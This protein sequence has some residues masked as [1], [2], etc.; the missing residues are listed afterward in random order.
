MLHAAQLPRLTPHGEMVGPDG[1]IRA[2]GRAVT[3]QSRNRSGTGNSGHWNRE[4]G[5]GRL[6]A[7]AISLSDSARSKL[8]GT[9]GVGYGQGKFSDSNNGR[10]LLRNSLRSARVGAIKDYRAFDR[11]ACRND[12]AFTVITSAPAVWA[13]RI[14]RSPR[15][16]SHCRPRR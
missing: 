12:R 8:S 15:P 7:V 16:R 3:V 14:C 1:Y 10:G 5:S 4:I 9:E 2:A 13:K 11:A 6:W